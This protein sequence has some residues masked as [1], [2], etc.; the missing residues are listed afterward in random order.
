MAKKRSIK[1]KAYIEIPEEIYEGVYK[2][3]HQ[4]QNS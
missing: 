4:S 1:K 3:D 2:H